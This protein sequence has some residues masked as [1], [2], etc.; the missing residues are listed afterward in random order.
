M[1]EDKKRSRE[2]DAA[3]QARLSQLELE[4]RLRL[5]R[6]APTVGGEAIKD[7]PRR[8]FGSAQG[9]AH[10]RH[11]EYQRRGPS[12]PPPPTPI[13]EPGKARFGG[14]YLQPPLPGIISADATPGN[15]LI[16]PVPAKP[17]PT[18][19]PAPDK[20]VRTRPLQ[21]VGQP[22]SP[23]ASGGPAPSGVMPSGRPLPATGPPVAPAKEAAA[24]RPAP[25][26]PAVPVSAQFDPKPKVVGGNALGKAPL[27]PLYHAG[28]KAAQEAEKARVGD[29]PEAVAKADVVVP[30]GSEV[31]RDGPKAPRVKRFKNPTLAP[32]AKE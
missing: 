16:A 1:G 7:T 32:K 8:G 26:G 20:E 12:P 29:K 15:E 30:E 24:A 21:G 23:P 31:T 27:P 10:L 2:S 6:N 9:I 22:P 25:A 5:Q 18:P 13:P 19:A 17:T 28:M 3:L 4:N 11:T 14:T